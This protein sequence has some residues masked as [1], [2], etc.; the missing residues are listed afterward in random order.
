MRMSF[1]DANEYLQNGEESR[2]T[3][4]WW[5]SEAPQIEGIVA[6]HELLEAVMSGLNYL[7]VTIPTMV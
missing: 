5:A 1:K 6:G 2:F 4:E 7:R 3:R